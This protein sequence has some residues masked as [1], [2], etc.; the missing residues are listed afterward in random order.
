MLGVIERRNK[1]VL[2]DNHCTMLLVIDVVGTNIACITLT[3]GRQDSPLQL[4]NNISM[5]GLPCLC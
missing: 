4:E 2:A 1:K 3:I 5:T